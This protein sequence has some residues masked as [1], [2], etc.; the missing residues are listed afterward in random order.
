MKKT[1]MLIPFIC[2]SLLLAACAGYES[3]PL[4]YKYASYIAKETQ[5]KEWEYTYSLIEP[6]KDGYFIT[7]YCYSP[8]KSISNWCCKGTGENIKCELL[9]LVHY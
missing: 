3:K 2:V 1:M 4:H 7:F 8:S 5:A 6:T 9:T